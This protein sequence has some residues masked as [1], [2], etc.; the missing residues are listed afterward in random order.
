MARERKEGGV[1]EWG[2]RVGEEEEDERGKKI[3]TKR[4]KMRK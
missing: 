1:G 4:G 3:R 2:E